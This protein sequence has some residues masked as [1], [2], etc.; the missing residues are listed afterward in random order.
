MIMKKIEFNDII[1]A[2]VT[3]MGRE[4]L[5][6]RICGVMSMTELLRHV[7]KELGTYMGLITLNLRNMS[8]GWSQTSCYRLS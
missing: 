2:R 8:Q 6:V 7:R 4:L 1:F 3:T 5:S